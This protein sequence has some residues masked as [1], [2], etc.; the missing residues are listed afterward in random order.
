MNIF[1]FFVSVLLTSSFWFHF[2]FSSHQPVLLFVF[3]TLSTF[4]SNSPFRSFFFFSFLP[5]NLYLYFVFYTH[6]SSPLLKSLYSF[7][8]TIL[9]LSH[10]TLTPF[11]LLFL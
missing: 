1:F 6:S 7:Q 9:F 3:F 4:T 2:L 8:A 5:H 11:T 10:I